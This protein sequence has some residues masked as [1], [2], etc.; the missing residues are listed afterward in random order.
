MK[1]VR[2]IAYTRASPDNFDQKA[3]CERRQRADGMAYCG[4]AV[5]DSQ[6]SGTKCRNSS[7]RTQLSSTRG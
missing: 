2:L 7:G 4:L 1:V 3:A 5:I 6:I